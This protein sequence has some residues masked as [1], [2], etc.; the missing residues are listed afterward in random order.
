M[1]Q[2]LDNVRH[3]RERGTILQ[4]LQQEYSGRMTRA[5]DL[6]GAL[7]L[8]GYPM[9]MEDLGFH[10]VYLSD[11]GYVKITRAAETAG[12]RRDRVGAG[13]PDAIVFCKLLPRGLRLIDGAE[14]ENAGVRF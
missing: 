1:A 3:A 11:E 5:A 9:S 13:D 4:A 12:Y 14:P 2:T 7:D 8:L 10:L 6:A